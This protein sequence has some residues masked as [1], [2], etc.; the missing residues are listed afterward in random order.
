M[1][2]YL[3]LL[4]LAAI[5][6]NACSQTN[7][8]IE[9]KKASEMISVV[10]FVNHITYGEGKAHFWSDETELQTIT[11]DEIASM[12]VQEQD[13][14][15]TSL[16]PSRFRKD[17]DFDIAFTD[18]DHLW[19]AEPEVTD[20][21]K[22]TYD[23]FMIHST[24]DKHVSIIY[25]GTKASVTG[26]PE[27]VTID[28]DGCHVTVHSEMSGVEYTLN[29]QSENGSFKLYSERKSLVVLNGVQLTN[30]NGP[31]INSQSK[32][33]LFI[34]TA[35]NTV[36]TLTDGKTYKK[37]SGEDQRGCLFAEGKI[38]MSG[39]GELYVNG[40]KK[41]GIASDDNIHIISGFVRANAYA[42]KGKAIYAK[43]IF[44]MGGGSVQALGNGIASKGIASDSI[45]TVNGGLIKVITTGNAIY[46][47]EKQDYTSCC[48]I[49]SEYDMILQ[50]GDIFVMST[51]TGGKGISAGNSYFED[52]TKEVFVGELKI[53]GS[54]IWVRTTGAR[55]PEIK[56]E[57]EHG[58]KLGAA[59]SPKGI[60]SADKI[61]VNDGEIYVRCSGGYAAEG[62]E[63]KKVITINGGK[64][65]SYCVDDGMNGEGAY[66]KGGDVFICSSANDGFD[67][68]FLGLTGGSLYTIGAPVDQMGLDTDGKTFYISQGHCTA[69]GANNCIPFGNANTQPSVMIY[70]HH[71][72]SF[73][74]I[75]DTDGNVVESIEVPNYYIGSKNS[76]GKLGN[77]ISIL[78]GGETLEKGKTYKVYSYAHSPNDT[79]VLE[80]E[81]TTD[82]TV[83][84]LGEFNKY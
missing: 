1:K 26:T 62:I 68:S 23:D 24:W 82:S 29:G 41:C 20:T 53:D 11:M 34:H 18:T 42:Q 40:H 12:S 8:Y 59:A 38:C 76:D 75:T 80:Y 39:E 83:T 69:V 35:K 48:G 37:V 44:M 36:N 31:A 7:I 77:N 63:S 32:K 65:R 61:T 46:E 25:D 2:K 66:I 72:V 79:P 21:T 5:A 56:V 60:K 58:D 15:R 16:I 57:D 4:F 17:F 43:D 9:Q 22:N 71:N 3:A 81:F 64:I 13:T 84:T 45:I 33:R 51:G 70:L 14:L 27:G 73:L 30:P 49:K 55:I 74:Q 19:T 50:G 47:D 28:V 52:E 67:V 6:G 10:P 78:T 54:R